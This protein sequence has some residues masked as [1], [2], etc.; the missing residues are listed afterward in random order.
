M[1]KVWIGMKKK[2]TALI[3]AAAM[4][5]SIFAGCGSGPAPGE[6]SSQNIGAGAGETLILSEPGNYTEKKEYGDVVLKAD[7][8]VLENALIH[9]S[10][11][12]DKTV[13]EGD[14]T[15]R[16]CTV[17]GDVY[18]YGGGSHSVHF[19]NCILN[20]LIAEK[21]GLRVVLDSRT[22][23][24]AVSVRASARFEISAAVERV[25]IETG[26]TDSELLFT[27]EAQA[28]KVTLNAAARLEQNCPLEELNVGRKA[29]GSSLLLSAKTEKV[30]L[31]GA[32]SV[33]VQA[34]VGELVLTG[35]ASG[36]EVA[37]AE[38]AQVDTL[39]TSVPLTLSGEGAVKRAISD[40]KAKL[41]GDLVPATVEEKEAPVLEADGTASANLATPTKAPTA[42]AA[43]TKK[44]VPMPVPTPWNP[45]TVTTPTAAPTATATPAVTSTP[46]PSPAPTPTP[47]PTAAPV[48]VWDGTADTSWYTGDAQSY[49]LQSAEQL[50]GLA[51]L[52]NGG[53]DFAGVTVTLG[54]S[55]D[56]D[57]REWTPIGR[58]SRSG[59]GLAAG[60]TPF[61]GVFDGNSKT[62]AGL[63]ISATSGADAGVG[64]FGAVAGSG[65]AVKGLTLTDVKVEVASS[66]ALG[67]VTGLLT[68]GAMVS[69]CHVEGGT[70]SGTQGVGGI[71]GRGL[72][73]G[74]VE[75]C[76]N[77][78]VV[79]ASSANAGGIAGAMYYDQDPAGAGDRAPFAVR[80][81]ENSGAVKGQSVAVG[82]IVG[83]STTCDISNCTNSG[84]V[85]GGGTSVGGIAGEQK[86]GGTVSGCT[87]KAAATVSG[88]QY[89]G[90]IV[91]W[92]R[93]NGA[94]STYNTSLSV[95]VKDCVN[96]APVEGTNCVAGIVGD[97]YW[98]CT[99]TGC[100]NSG[101]I[102]STGMGAGVAV[103]QSLSAGGG[104][105]DNYSAARANR[106]E[107]SGC[108]N[109]GA[110]NTSPRA[111]ILYVNSSDG[112]GCTVV[113][114]G[115]KLVDGDKILAITDGTNIYGTLAEAVAG[116]PDGATISLPEG[117]YDETVTTA[118]TLTI[119]GSGT[120]KTVLAPSASGARAIVVDRGCISTTA[121]AAAAAGSL[122]LEHLSMELPAQGRGVLVENTSNYTVRLKDVDA[123]TK[124]TGTAFLYLR[125][126]VVGGEKRVQ[127]DL[128][129][130]AEGF[131][132][133]AAGDLT[134]DRIYSAFH[135]GNLTGGGLRLQNC[136]VRGARYAVNLQQSAGLAVEV[137]A[138]TVQG[139]TTLNAISNNCTFEVNGSTLI[140]YNS[141]TGGSN[142]YSVLVIDGGQIIG[143]DPVQGYTNTLHVA[144]STL[145]AVRA[146]GCC[147]EKYLSIQYSATQNQAVFEN[148]VFEAENDPLGGG[149][150]LDVGPG[151]RLAVNGVEVS[152]AA[153]QFTKED[154][155]DYW[156]LRV[157]SAGTVTGEWYDDGTKATISTD[158][159]LHILKTEA[160]SRKVWGY[161]SAVTEAAGQKCS[162]TCDLDIRQIAETNIPV[163]G[164]AFT[165]ESGDA[166]TLAVDEARRFSVVLQPADTTHR[167][168]TWTSSDE[169]VATVAVDPQDPA[170]AQVTA[171]T[172]GQ[173]VLSA[174]AGGVTAQIT[175]TV[176][177]AA[178]RM[179]APLAEQDLEEQSEDA[180][181]ATPQE[182]PGPDAPQATAGPAG[183]ATPSP[184]PTIGPT[185][186]PTWTPEPLP[187][188]EAVASP[189]PAA[190][191]VLGPTPDPTW[192][193]EPLPT[194][195]TATEEKAAPV[196]GPTPSPNWTPEPLRPEGE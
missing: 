167:T 153:P 47:T 7:G 140:G 40:E 132:L 101:A 113:V 185:P 55:L 187:T 65:A 88:N 152:N 120:G 174:T 4:V 76:S 11:T 148:V 41:G 9:G 144:G 184:A 166:A 19:E 131:R 43:P 5:A 39:A 24:G 191:P 178:N 21:K 110:V 149:S 92:V 106:V 128:F 60:S 141:M 147:V 95:T 8:I 171:L 48:L 27:E 192:T 36:S 38:G 151:D 84:T 28:S 82:G 145:R 117:R 157:S 129:V 59:G 69:D 111:E 63:A 50:A 135:F 97:I 72:K 71:V 74:V 119:R 52:V 182:T 180:S 114:D 57:G 75:N 17:E 127:R 32:C 70:V 109:S 177:T 85:T 183:E 118:K 173:T 22:Q 86:F 104:K 10:L 172:A 124:D 122:T 107:V 31:S 133:N 49:V 125:G 89:V 126:E 161:F 16:G 29:S 58:S 142:N 2:I 195:Q 162:V 67:A 146:P 160:E 34:D 170:S 54:V 12:V 189:T 137:T 115:V 138:S 1:D 18:L 190:T 25:L 93:Y 51:D 105:D 112:D 73:T 168:V 79:T 163:E 136:D 102:T 100:T 154:D 108:V 130:E 23:T 176:E 159:A 91:G 46:T 169:S 13:G 6:S 116:A 94:G 14:A 164:I 44:P 68:D 194:P 61:A 15:L 81:C 196:I 188:Q 156:L 83:L 90:G 181:D 20:T 155:G 158:T 64:L 193:P 143:V 87:N 33:E 78:A 77:A 35:N 66:K 186:D 56:L 175:L 139:W 121:A 98:S 26:A 134:I 30:V 165:G 96:E 123:S 80:G 37:V 42:T 53:N 3:L 99:L 150:G 45:G 179:L 103:E 62:I